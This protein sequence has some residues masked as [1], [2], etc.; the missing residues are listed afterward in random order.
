MV[1]ILKFYEYNWFINYEKVGYYY[2]VVE[3]IY[4]GIAKF[5]LYYKINIYISGLIFFIIFIVCYKLDLKLYTIFC[6]NINDIFSFKQIQNSNYK[7][8]PIDFLDFFREWKVIIIIIIVI[9]FFCISYYFYGLK[10][11]LSKFIGYIYRRLNFLLNL[12]IFLYL[13]DINSVDFIE[14][15]FIFIML[16]IVLFMINLIYYLI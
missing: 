14:Y 4:A 15:N 5:T 13:L 16:I 2:F 10:E 8:I 1:K 7:N 3:I 11:S 12:E 6:E 9:I